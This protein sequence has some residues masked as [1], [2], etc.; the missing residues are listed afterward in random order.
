MLLVSCSHRH[1][2]R[3]PSRCSRVKK[4]RMGGKSGQRPHKKR[5]NHRPGKGQGQHMS[6]L[7]GWE[8]RVD[9][10]LDLDMRVDT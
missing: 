7:S 10:D 8:G 2:P 9:L 1:R 4:Q 6:P 5:Q 3:K